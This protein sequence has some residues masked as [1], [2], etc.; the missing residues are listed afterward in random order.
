M[1]WYAPLL[2]IVTK[3]DTKRFIVVGASCLIVVGLPPSWREYLGCEDILV[4]VRGWVA[5]FGVIC[6]SIGLLFCVGKVWNW[7]NGLW[8]KWWMPHKV[9]A[10]IKE[11][12]RQ[13]LELLA[14]YIHGDVMT[15]TMDFDN[16]VAASLVNRRI[17]YRADNYLILASDVP[18]NLHP[19][20]NKILER[21]SDLKQRILN[22]FSEDN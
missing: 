10:E 17:L 11:L 18:F 7:L 6:F 3:W 12:S 13:E 21:D 22:N 20:V 8:D 1:S 4:K 19:C 5:M 14:D 16:G 2:D 15:L 9:K